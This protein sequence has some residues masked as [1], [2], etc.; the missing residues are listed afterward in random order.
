MCQEQGKD[1]VVLPVSV[2]MRGS[3][4]LGQSCR[5]PHRRGAGALGHVLSS[6][7][8]IKEKLSQG[9][10]LVVD[11][12]AFSGVAFTSAKEVSAAGQPPLSTQAQGSASFPFAPSSR[13]SI[14]FI[15]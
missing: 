2:H 6:R 5:D 10:N 13:L 11:R 3:R 15:S 9:V 12:Y 4:G 7:P 8:F 14:V 1:W